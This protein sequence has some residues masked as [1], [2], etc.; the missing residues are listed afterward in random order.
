MRLD[1]PS[2]TLP[3]ALAIVAIVA[4]E[5]IPDIDSKPVGTGPFRFKAFNAG[6]NLDLEAFP[7]YWEKDASG[8]ALPYL[9]GVTVR[10]LSDVNALFTSLASGT[11]QAMWQI[12][13]QLQ[14]QAE[15]APTVQLVPAKFKTT[16]DEYFFQADV[17]PFDNVIARQALLLA[18]DK[19]A[20]VDAGYFGKADPRWNNNIVPPGS[21]AEK[22]GI[23]DIKRDPAKA[24]Q[25]F[26]QAGVKTIKF[27][28]YTVTPQF[29][30]ISQVMERNLAEAGVALTL[31]FTDLTTWLARI[32]V[33]SQSEA[34]GNGDEGNGYAVNISVNPP[35]PGMPLAMWGCHTH[36]GSH[37]CDEELAKAARD[38]ASS[39]DLTKRKEAYAR[40][41]DIWQKDVPAV[42]NGVRA[43]THASIKKVHGLADDDGALNYRYAWM[44]K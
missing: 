30:P 2:G 43:F 28:G 8:G 33:G 38:G 35:E 42:I 32:K 20:M 21:W 24:K 37:F 14:V 10:T 31:D 4:K 13:E 22:P 19:Q 7:D 18:L 17:A 36:F 9:D 34:W 26:E 25:L 44:E 15:S 23:P 16:Y 40:Y 3:A 41:Q 27:L 11:V 5:N 39:S 1:Q 6:M 12:P 29:R